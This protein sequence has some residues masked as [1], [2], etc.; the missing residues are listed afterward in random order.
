M[1]RDAEYGLLGAIRSAGMTPPP[2]LEPGKV[3]RFRGEGKS[4]KNRSGWAILFEDGSG[5]A[6]GNWSGGVTSTW[7]PKRRERLMTAAGRARR[8]RQIEEAKHLAA[9]ER[10]RDNDAA[11]TR[12]QDIWRAL[13]PAP[14]DH[15][16][17]VSKGIGP[18]KA[19][20]NGRALVLPVRTIQ[21]KIVSLQYI[22][23]DG[24]KRFLKGGLIQGGVIP[25]KWTLPVPETVYITEGWATA[26]TVA[27]GRVFPVP[28]KA[29][30]AAALNAGNL[31]PFALVFR[32][33]YPNVPIVI[34]R[35]DDRNTPGNPGRAKATEA[36]AA[37][38][39]KVM[40]PAWPPGCPDTLTDFNDLARWEDQHKKK[41]R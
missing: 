4:R 12:A 35:D 31:K 21:G 36:A 38:G 28:K 8:K 29:M 1:N 14:G 19:R 26:C 15:P 5:G 40:K 17:L 33:H 30:V 32:R 13:D 10:A 23:P 39:G 18:H 2:R 41:V 25:V 34:C 7:F 16:Y 20:F 3:V 6:F 37:V 27:E 24:T 22:S 9:A 11:A